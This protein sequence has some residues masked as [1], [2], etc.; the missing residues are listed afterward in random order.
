MEKKY[1]DFSMQDAMRL[2]K[3]DAGQQLLQLLRS[4]HGDAARSAME[5]TQNGDIIQAQKALQ[6][7][8]S[9]PKAQALLRQLQEERH[10]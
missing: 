6:A 7:F 4:G 9:D 8:L 10:G 3:S 1:Q 2:A 5:N